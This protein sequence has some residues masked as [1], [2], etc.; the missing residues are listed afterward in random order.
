MPSPL[1]LLTLLIPIL[2]ITFWLSPLS[3]K[4]RV[5]VELMGWDGLLDI[6]KETIAQRLLGVKETHSRVAFH[7]FIDTITQAEIKYLVPQRRVVDDATIAEG[8]RFFSHL[9]QSGLRMYLEA[10]LDRPHFT[11]MVGPF[12]KV[13][14]DNPDAFYYSSLIRRDGSYVISGKKTGEDYLSFTIYESNCIGCFS[15]RIISDLNHLQMHFE[16][17]G[18]Y[19]IYVGPS[20]PPPSSSTIKNYL[21]LSTCSSN[22]F[23]QV[24]SRHYFEREVSVQLNISARIQDL[25]IN[26]I[27]TST[28]TTIPAFPGRLTDMESAERWG[29]VASF[30]TSHSINME[31]D[32]AK[33]PKWFSFTPNIF[34]PPTLFRKENSGQVG[35]VDIAYSAAPFKFE[36]VETQGLI[37]TGK[38][39]SCVFANVAL[40]NVFLQ[41]L[42][43][44]RNNP[45]SLNRKQLKSWNKE[46]GTFRII[47]SKTKPTAKHII[48][49]PFDWLFSEGRRDGTVFFRFLLPET[50]SIETPKTE[51]VVVV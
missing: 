45:V 47:L 51:L 35:A 31:Q 33:A 23:P 48:D 30:I 49:Q 5:A 12:L 39:P 29:R 36:Q 46:T 21:S 6:T 15:Q 38:M 43:Y 24:I 44:E 4:I 20:K 32:P 19:K 41:T 14:G 3:F 34:G 28:T 25:K 22:G 18:S 10:D 1:T 11:E 9:I 2:A 7:E 16:S 17:D 50:D 13:L 40:W 37:I 27:A 42:S 26:N 8:H